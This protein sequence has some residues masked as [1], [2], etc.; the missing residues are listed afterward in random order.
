M[1]GVVLSI[2]SMIAV[3]VGGSQPSEYA[4][5]VYK[6]LGLYSFLF[7]RYA[8]LVCSGSP[9]NQI[10]DRSSDRFVRDERT[11]PDDGRARWSVCLLFQLHLVGGI[12]ALELARRCVDGGISDL[13]GSWVRRPTDWFIGQ[14]DY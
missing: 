13:P 14:V 8:G 7:D 9:A 2:V 10:D 4:S 11:P 5:L 1:G 12:S 6:V 3:A